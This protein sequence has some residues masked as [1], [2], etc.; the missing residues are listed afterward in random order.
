MNNKLSIVR[1]SSAHLLASS[2]VKIFPGTKV[3]IGPVV[4]NGF[5]YDFDF[6]K[7]ISEL[8]LPKIE[9]EMKKQQSKN[10]I[11]EQKWISLNEA[12]ELFKDEPYKMEII[13]EIEKGERDDFGQKGKVSIY[14]SGD[15]VDLCKGPHVAKNSEIGFFKLLSLAGAYWKGSEKNKMLTRIYGICFETKEEL[16]KYIWQVEEAKKRDHRKLGKSLDLFIIDDNIG[17]GLPLLTPKGT[18]I[19][20]RILEYESQLELQAGFQRVSTPHIG[21]VEI[22]KKTG[23]WQHYRETMYAPFGIEGDEYVLKPMNCPHHYMI[24]SSKPRSYK[25]LPVRLSEPGTCYRFEKSGELSGLLR[26]RALTID[27]AHILMTEE[28]VESEFKL[29]IEMVAK[30]F[31]AFKLDDYYVRLSLSDPSDAVKYIADP[32]IWQRGGELLEK[33]VRNNKLKYTTVSGEASFYGPKLDYIVKDSLGREWQMSTLQLD[34]FMGKR[35]NL[36]YTDEKGKKQHPI[37]LHRGLTGSLERTLAILIE[38]F[39]GAFPLWLAPVQLAILPISQRHVQY[40]RELQSLFM[41]AHIRPELDERS[42]TIGAKIR[43]AA[44]QKIPYLAIIGDR[45]R[46]NKS[47]SARTRVGKDLGK[48]DLR[49]F[50]ALLNNEIDKKI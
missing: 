11:F 3:A 37:I 50:I 33:I 18:I 49:K 8:E 41:E 9:K 23:H 42:E 31:A 16:D 13:S 36:T 10:S 45:E 6:Q 17:R 4:E 44:L 2:V 14:K 48:M 35:L 28:Q 22:Y 1:H 26:V 38:H 12:K 47:V 24:Y 15:F 46:E 39:G 32:K 5:Y 43:E 19:K 30:M 7:P 21:R 25:D 27:D 20:D 40:G 29:C 34:L